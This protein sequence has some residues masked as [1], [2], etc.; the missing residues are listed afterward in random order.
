MP[1]ARK[2]H[3]LMLEALRMLRGSGAP[4]RS[5]SSWSIRDRH[6]DGP[7]GLREAAQ[8][9]RGFACDPLAHQ[10]RAVGS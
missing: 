1:S 8:A 4:G 9:L 7:Y 10:R 6:G 3:P 2:I 5:A